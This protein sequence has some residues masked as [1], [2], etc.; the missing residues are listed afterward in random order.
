MTLG[1]GAV[2]VVDGHCE[3][4]PHDAS[5]ALQ[6]CM[7]AVADG[8]CRAGIHWGMCVTRDDAVIGRVVR[9]AERLAA[10]AHPGE[11]VSSW[12]CWQRAVAECEQEDVHLE[13]IRLVEVPAAACSVTAVRVVPQRENSSL[14]S[15]GAT[16][17]S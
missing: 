11:V 6:H 3:W 17:S 8:R 15:A 12:P 5:A 1:V 13:E 14:S 16:T 9:V 10:I 4:F 2:A 7:D